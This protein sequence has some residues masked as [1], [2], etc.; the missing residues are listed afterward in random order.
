MKRRYMAGLCFVAAGAGFFVVSNERSVDEMEGKE[1]KQVMK[2]KPIPVNPMT[3]VSDS[4]GTRNGVLVRMPRSD[5]AVRV[6]TRVVV[7]YSVVDYDGVEHVL[8]DKQTDLNFP[9]A[10]RPVSTWGTDSYLLS[11]DSEISPPLRKTLIRILLEELEASGL[12]VNR[13]DPNDASTFKESDLALSEQV[14]PHIY[15]LFDDPSYK[16]YRPLDLI[17]EP[18]SRRL[19]PS[20]GSFQWQRGIRSP[21][22]TYR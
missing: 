12:P 22:A 10:V 7:R 9:S 6:L 8:A 11:I 1:S 14:G 21:G 17:D 20:S 13:I 18:A 19:H 3:F 2:R 15:Q 4:N 16:G 5:A